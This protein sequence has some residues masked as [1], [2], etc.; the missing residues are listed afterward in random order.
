MVFTYDQIFGTEINPETNVGVGAASG[1][2]MTLIGL[3]F[4]AVVSFIK[5]GQ[6]MNIKE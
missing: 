2:M 4:F 1:V 3:F 6:I 5:K